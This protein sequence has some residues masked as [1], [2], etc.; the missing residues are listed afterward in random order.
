MKNDREISETIRTSVADCTR[1]VDEAPSIRYKIMQQVKGE[2]PMAKKISVAFIVAMALL[3]ASAAALAG[4]LLWQNIGEK[5]A[6][7]ESENGYYDTWNTEAKLE[8]I[9]MLYDMGELKDNA[10]AEKLLSTD[11]DEAEKDTLCDQIMT[12]YVSGTSDT[13]TLLSI[14]EK[15][16]GDIDTWSQE[17]KVW[18]NELL[19]SNQMLTAEDTNYVLSNEQEL[20]QEQAAETAKQFLIGKGASNLDQAK[21]EATLTEDTEDAF[22]DGYQVSFKG[23]RVWSIVFELNEENLAYGGSYHVDLQSDGT[24]LNYETPRLTKLFMTGLLPDENAI[25]EGQALDAGIKAILSQFGVQED[26]LTGIQAFFGEIN[27][28]NE[29]VA[30]AAW[31]ERLWA[32]DTDQKYYALLT[33]EGEVV[34]VGSHK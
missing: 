27:L 11:I 34:Y 26:D 9:R 12:A 24:L 14:L 2:K 3:A 32:V 10:D 16:H 29:D 25:S 7:L 28:K 20:T 1:R 6:P 8:L 31:K 17:D 23:R 19:R 5:V 18:Y 22:V 4:A 13:V 30:H 15:L 21:V 33:A